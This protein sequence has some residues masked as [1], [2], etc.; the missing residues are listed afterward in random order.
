MILEN[1]IVIGVIK[2]N[3]SYEFIMAEYEGYQAHF[4]GLNTKDI[5]LITSL[6]QSSTLNLNSVHIS[7]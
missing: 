1:K 7:G 2:G 4:L 3:S 5:V 6:K